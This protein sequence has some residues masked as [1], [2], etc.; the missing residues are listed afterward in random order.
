MKRKI[1]GLFVV[2]IMIC[3]LTGCIKYNATMEIRNNKSMTFS[4]IYGMAN[5]VMG[6]TDSQDNE[7]MS[8]EEKKSLIN[9]GFTI[10]DYKDDNYTGYIISKEYS[11]IDDISSDIDSEYSLSNMFEETTNSKLFKVEKGT[12]KNT[13]YAN[14]KFDSSDD[15]E[16]KSSDEIT[17]NDGNSND[18]SNLGNTLESQFDLKFMVKLPYAAISSNATE[19]SEDGKQLTWKL[20][21]GKNEN[22]QFQFELENST[23]NASKAV[24]N[25]NTNSFTARF[26]NKANMP[27]I[28]GA[29]IIFLISVIVVIGIY[30]KANKENKKN[31]KKSLQSTTPVTQ[32]ASVA[33][34]TQQAPV[35]PVAQP[36]PVAPVTQ[37]ASVAPVTQQAPAAPVTQQAPVAPVAQPTPVA[38]VTQQASV[39]PV[40]QPAPVAPV[41]QPAPAAP[42]TQPAPVAPVAQPTPV[43]PVTSNESNNID[44]DTSII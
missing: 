15:E 42:V 34:V 1:L 19:K 24:S 26:F 10:N 5:S 9:Q 16:I 20:T 27:I 25:K 11:N 43:A 41:T 7:I 39:A 12:K 2:L 40:T 28:I 23:G 6:M 17:D 38:P 30:I 37:Q 4:I 14:F 31:N 3:S 21:T 32:Q 8:D 36:T 29:G 18:L 13:Y 33:P 44:N 22:I 35:A